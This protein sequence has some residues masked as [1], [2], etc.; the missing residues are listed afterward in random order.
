M[1]LKI[2]EIQESRPDPERHYSGTSKRDRPRPRMGDCQRR[3]YQ[4][5]KRLGEAV[6]EGI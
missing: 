2:V 5:N 4:W 6:D 1:R 3:F